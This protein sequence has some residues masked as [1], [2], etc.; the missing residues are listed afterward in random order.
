VS[1]PERL[2]ASVELVEKGKTVLFDL[3]HFREPARAFALHH[4][5]GGVWLEQAVDPVT[6]RADQS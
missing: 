4:G 1:V 3:V 6:V 5:G 2:C